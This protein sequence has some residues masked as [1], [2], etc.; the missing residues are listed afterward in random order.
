MRKPGVPAPLM[1]RLPSLARTHVP[2]APKRPSNANSPIA[3]QKNTGERVV[4][5]SDR[6]TI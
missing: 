4:A 5:G 1:T 2:T 3:I 6:G